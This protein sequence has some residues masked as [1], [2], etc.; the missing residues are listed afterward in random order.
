MDT[1]RIEPYTSMPWSFSTSLYS[2]QETPFCSQNPLFSLSVLC[3]QDVLFPASCSFGSTEPLKSN[4]LVSVH[5]F[6]HSIFQILSFPVTSTHPSGVSVDNTFSRTFSLM[7]TVASTTRTSPLMCFLGLSISQS[8]GFPYPS[9][10]SMH[11]KTFLCT[12]GHMHIYC[13]CEK[14]E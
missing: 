11:G 3:T 1:F 8:A 10:L 13:V 14:G 7:F 9:K 4:L 5:G 12:Q 2:P 6:D